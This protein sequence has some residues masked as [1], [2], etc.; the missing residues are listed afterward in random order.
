MS[1]ELRNTLAG[2]ARSDGVKMLKEG[3]RVLLAAFED[4]PEEQATVLE[5]AGNFVIVEV[6][7]LHNERDDGIR[8]LT[9]DQILKILSSRNA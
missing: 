9:T 1:R 7:N 8:E 3:N 2:L 4:E 5:V 6:D